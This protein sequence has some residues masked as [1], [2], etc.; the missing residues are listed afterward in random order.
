MV[1]V[2][3]REHQGEEQVKDDVSVIDA[4]AVVVVV[5]VVVVVSTVVDTVVVDTVVVDTVVAAIFK[6]GRSP[7]AFFIALLVKSHF[8]AS[9]LASVEARGPCIDL[10]DDW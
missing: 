4:V 1:S 7:I 8:D 10:L 2:S 9:V 5:V 6:G 3:L